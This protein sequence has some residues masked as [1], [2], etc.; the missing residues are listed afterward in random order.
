MKKTQEAFQKIR[1]E[2]GADI[3]TVPENEIPQWVVKVSPCYE[4]FSKKYPEAF[5]DFVRLHE[6]HGRTWPPA[7]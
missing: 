1:N 3:F 5:K 2:F 7:F 4:R 6:M